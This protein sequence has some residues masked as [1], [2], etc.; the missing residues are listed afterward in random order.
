MIS[1]AKSLRVRNMKLRPQDFESCGITKSLLDRL[2]P[3]ITPSPG[4]RANSVELSFFH[5][6][7]GSM[8]NERHSH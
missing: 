4:T 2:R 1:H 3:L 6:K 7:K 8:R 5:V